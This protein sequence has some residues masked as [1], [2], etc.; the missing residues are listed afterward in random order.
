[1]ATASKVEVVTI[2]G[3]KT[4]VLLDLALDL[5]KKCGPDLDMEALYF[6][7]GSLSCTYLLARHQK[8]ARGPKNLRAELEEVERAL[9][10]VQETIEKLDF[11]AKI[12][13]AQALTHPSS[14][15]MSLRFTDIEAFREQ[16][17]HHQVALQRARAA[18][19]IGRGRPRLD[20]LRWL[21][22]ELVAVYEQHAGR[23]FRYDQ[24]NGEFLTDGA[25][26]IEKVVQKI[27]PGVTESNIATALRDVRKH[28][29]RLSPRAKL[30]AELHPEIEP[31]IAI[32][33]RDAE[34]WRRARPPTI[35]EKPTQKRGHF[36]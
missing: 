22:R 11:S 4:D 15:L 24:V 32:W 26:W 5:A 7:L 35:N 2:P 18:M 36:S 10:H 12:L 13:W 19:P 3:V 23:P 33:D 34:I 29:S 21:R 1:M 17:A 8:R 9:K 28:S 14:S 20:L 16:A 31:L 6:S 27:D 30:Q 25:Q